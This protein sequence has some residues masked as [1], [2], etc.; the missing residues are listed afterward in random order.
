MECLCYENSAWSKMGSEIKVEVIHKETI[1]PSSPTPPHLESLSLSVFDQ[2]QPEFY[3]P[4]L[5]FY[6]NS[7]NEINI[8]HHSLAA[9]RSSLLKTSLSKTLTHFYPFAGKFEYNV[10]I[11][12]NDHGAAFLQAQVNCPISTV[13]EKPDHE[14]LK[15][16]LPADIASTQEVA[17]H[18]LLVQANFF[19]CGGMAIGVNI[20]HKVGD[21]FTFSK[22]INSWAAVSF[23]SSASDH[24]V[25]PAV[26]FG[27][28]AS[29]CPPLDFFNSRQPIVEFAKEKSVTERFVFEASKIDALKSKAASSTVPNPTRVEV[30][31]ALIW[32]CAT[33][34]SRSN[35]GSVRPSVWCQV[36]NMRKRSGQ[37][38]TE[39]SLG[40]FV[41]YFASMTME[42]EIDLQSLVAKFRKGIEEF[43]EKYPN[44]VSP[45]D[46]CQTIQESGNLMTKDGIDNYSCSSWCRF[47]FYEANFGWGTPSWVSIRT[48][49]AKNTI[50]LTD[51]RDGKGIEV[52][53]ALKEE[54]MAIIGSNEELL[55]YTSL[56]PAAI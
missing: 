42:S 37:P 28:V 43:K 14:V 12:C 2:L 21:A 24:I 10:S 8:D 19:E 31:S 22:F 49:A 15:Q 26:E 45:Q 32:K 29:L 54:D 1:I 27:V 23:G 51:T 25:V 40:N 5:L 50:Q 52:S 44:G 47:P 7:S 41:W 30:V 18:L 33:E 9:E 39:N 53:L 11:S 56:N 20:S 13:L 48:M 4:L 6:P 46:V 55:A 38:L 35:L 17:G 34:A 16:L 36:V 3:V